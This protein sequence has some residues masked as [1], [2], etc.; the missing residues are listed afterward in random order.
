VT[1]PLGAIN[2]DDV[3]TWKTMGTLVTLVGTAYVATLW[4]GLVVWTA[5]DIRERT[6]DSALHAISIGVVALFFLPG[7]LVYFLMRPGHTLE[8]QM[9]ERMEADMLRELRGQAACPRC[10]RRVS[11]D[12]A[13]CPYCATVLRTPCRNCGRPNGTAWEACAYCGAART[14]PLSGLRSPARPAPASAPMARGA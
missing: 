8:D 4:I 14:A 2:F 11:D 5:R 1:D 3:N 7:W 13:V 9:F 10:A 12:F 6:D